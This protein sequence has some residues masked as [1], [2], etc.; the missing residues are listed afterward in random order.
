M[1][2]SKVPVFHQTKK[3]LKN[4]YLDLTLF[5]A[6]C[7]N[8]IRLSKYFPNLIFFGKTIFHFKQ[9]DYHCEVSKMTRSFHLMLT[10]NA[11]SRTNDFSIPAAHSAWQS[12]PGI[13]QDWI[14]VYFILAWHSLM[15]FRHAEGLFFQLFCCKYFFFSLRWKCFLQVQSAVW[16]DFVFSWAVYLFLRLGKWLN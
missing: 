8:V 10:W 7:S 11:E 2:R 15:L 4:W 1:L 6:M 9:L 16:L 14:L 3:S 12:V 13:L 5:V